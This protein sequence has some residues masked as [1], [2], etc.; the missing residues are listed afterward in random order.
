MYCIQVQ[1]VLTDKCG[2]CHERDEVLTHIDNIWREDGQREGG[3][4]IT[5]NIGYVILICGDNVLPAK[6]ALKMD[7]ADDFR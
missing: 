6:A 4:Q 5:D 3:P 2:R 1:F 7:M